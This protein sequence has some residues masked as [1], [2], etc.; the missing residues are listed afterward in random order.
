KEQRKLKYKKK[1]KKNYLLINKLHLKGTGDE[2]GDYEEM[3]KEQQQH[4]YDPFTKTVKKKQPRKEW[5]PEERKRR[6]IY[7]RIKQ[8]KSC[9]AY[10]SLVTTLGKINCELYCHLVTKL[11]KL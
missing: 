9:I 1:Y 4:V 8:E 2:F 3:L 10:V 6:A 7:K 11:T 5:S